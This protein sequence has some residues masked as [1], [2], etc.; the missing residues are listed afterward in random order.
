MNWFDQ[1]ANAIGNLF[2]AALSSAVFAVFA[3]VLAKHSLEVQAG[4]TPFLGPMLYAKLPVGFFLYFIASGVSA[5]LGLE[6]KESNAIAALIGMA[7]PELILAVA[8]RIFKARG[9]ISDVPPEQP[10]QGGN[11]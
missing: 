5:Y 10:E 7:G 8:L 3:G 1:I 4:R 11:S 9:I 2:A 6:G